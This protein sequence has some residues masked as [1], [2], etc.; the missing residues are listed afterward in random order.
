MKKTHGTRRVNV[1]PW[2]PD[3]IIW[4]TE[5][6]LQYFY[7]HKSPVYDIL[8][9]SLAHSSAPT[10]VKNLLCQPWSNT[11]LFSVTFRY[12]YCNAMLISCLWTVIIASGNEHDWTPIKYL[13]VL[14]HNRTQSSCNNCSQ[15]IAK[16]LPTYYKKN[17]QKNHFFMSYLCE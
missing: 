14:H 13:N 12:C 9:D 16:I 10:L 3:F 1:K 5:F 8:P 17:N 6:W 7:F 2:F 11:T 15:Y 4:D